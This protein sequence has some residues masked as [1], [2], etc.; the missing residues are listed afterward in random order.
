MIWLKWG[1]LGHG[2][3]WTPQE[4]NPQIVTLLC[5]S[6]VLWCSLYWA[7]SVIEEIILLNG[8][9]LVNTKHY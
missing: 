6:G 7:T 3:L 1:V 5:V 2:S 8:Y 9:Y 4:F